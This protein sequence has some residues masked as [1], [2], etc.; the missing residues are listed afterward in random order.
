[1]FRRHCIQRDN[2]AVN[3]AANPL[4]WS[5][6]KQNELLQSLRQQQTPKSHTTS[7]HYSHYSHRPKRRQSRVCRLCREDNCK[8]SARVNCD[9]FHSTLQGDRSE[10]WLAFSRESHARLF[11]TQRVHASK[12]LT[13]RSR[14][15]Q[16]LSRPV[17]AEDEAMPS[18][19]EVGVNRDLSL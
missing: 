8:L 3:R 1:M 7:T 4:P 14:H 6:T 13:P 9:V 10:L 5:V 2:E 16:Q 17:G 11:L 15:T 18:P 12:L 19:T